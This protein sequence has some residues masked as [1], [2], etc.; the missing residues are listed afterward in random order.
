VTLVYLGTSEFAAEIL[1]RLAAT[2][3]HRP[4]LVVTPPDRRR[5]RGRRT[6]PTP[7]AELAGELGIDVLKTEATSDPEAL[8]RIRAVKPDVGVVCA[9]GQLIRE[10]LLSDLELLNV[11]P[12]LLPR[13]RGAAPIERAIMA[14]DSETGVSIMRLTE[15][16][17]SGPIA[18]QRSVRIGEDGFGALSGRLEELGAELLIEAL[19]RRAAGTL[20]LVEQDDD[21]ATYAEKIEASERQLDPRAEPADQLARRVRALNPHVGTYLELADGERLGVVEARAESG[22]LG[23]GTV[24]ANGELRIGTPDGELVVAEVR[25]AGGKAMEAA[26]YLRGHELP[27]LLA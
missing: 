26:A 5:G 10:P 6:S 12:S 22:Q 2:A 15:G 11:H 4:S 23:A 19:G 21:G 25:P 24:G 16:L 7:V 13:W 18:L 20:E 3:E 17:D 9:F 14:G 27:K 8:E 1:R